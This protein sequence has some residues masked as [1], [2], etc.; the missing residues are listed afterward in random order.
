MLI[1][2]RAHF[3]L[4]RNRGNRQTIITFLQE[5][6][7][8]LKI[9]EPSLNFPYLICDCR[10][11]GFSVLIL[12]LFRHWKSSFNIIRD[13]REPEYRIGLF[14]RELSDLNAESFK[15][16][17]DLF[18]VFWI[19]DKRLHLLVQWGI[20][21][22]LYD[23][24]RVLV[25]LTWNVNW[26]LYASRVVLVLI[27]FRKRHSRLH[28]WI[29]DK[30]VKNLFLLVFLFLV[31]FVKV[32][33]DWFGSQWVNFLFVFRD[34]FGFLRFFLL[35]TEY[36]FG[37]SWTFLHVILLSVWW[38]F[39]LV[40]R[41]YHFFDVN[42]H[43]LWFDSI[44]AFILRIFYGCIFTLWWKIFIL[45][46]ILQDFLRRLRSLIRFFRCGLKS[47]FLSRLISFLLWLILENDSL[48]FS[49]SLDE[50][51]HGVVIELE[52]FLVWKELLKLFWV[53]VLIENFLVKILLLCLNGLEIHQ[54]VLIYRR[55]L[56]FSMTKL[57]NFTKNLIHF[58]N[59]IYLQKTF[60][61][62]SLKRSFAMLISNEAS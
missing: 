35:K 14:L 38:F 51:L 1:I 24:V 61:S 59:H 33:L 20:V 22:L 15:K 8:P 41:N 50:F 18:A 29:A 2:K 32:L 48:E 13:I 7:D 58:I 16:R 62:F 46:L 11:W 6:M 56:Y 54:W 57:I 30:A 9:I 60:H 53:V 34:S 39:G 40:L 21:W 19:L 17:V 26:L 44:F 10:I 36:L 4:E 5:I 52:S 25:A 47:I 3:C 37:L 55:F 45:I 42:F 27:V 49:D 28:F 31:L 23:D 12:Y 43:P